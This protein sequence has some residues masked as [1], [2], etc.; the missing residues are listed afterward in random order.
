MDIQRKKYLLVESETDRKRR[1]TLAIVTETVDAHRIQKMRDLLTFEKLATWRRM[2]GFDRVADGEEN[3]LCG[4]R[5][6][7]L[8][9]EEYAA[10]LRSDLQELKDAISM[11]IQEVSN[12]IN[13]IKQGKVG[14]DEFAILK[15]LV[16]KRSR[17]AAQARVIVTPVD[18]VQRCSPCPLNPEMPPD[19]CF[20][21]ESSEGKMDP[22]LKEL[23]SPSAGTGLETFGQQCP[24]NEGTWDQGRTI[25]DGY[26]FV[27]MGSNQGGD[28]SSPTT[29]RSDTQA[30]RTTA[31]ITF[32]QQ[33]HKPRDKE[34]GSEE[35]K[36]FDPGGKGEKAPPWN[37]A[38]TS[39]FPFSV[40]SVEPR[41]ARCLCFVFFVCAYLSALFFKLLFFLGDH[42][43]AS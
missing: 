14:D 21:L 31:N 29:E 4:P 22:E 19:I 40:E 10:D 11:P 41:E 18:T 9:P 15:G 38:V 37:A 33:G 28:I 32:L 43:S 39:I 20:K 35:N 12:L 8:T 25:A 6:L 3:W 17:E 13:K 7:P 24:P 42:F 5:S 2:N 36:Q 30:V 26:S 1:R 27:G 34:K 16:E 23:E